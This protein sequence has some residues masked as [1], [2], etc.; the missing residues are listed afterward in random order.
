MARPVK[1]RLICSLPQ[2]ALFIPS[3]KENT[4][5]VV[6]GVDEY[7]T[8]RLIDYLGFTQEE[9]AGQ[10]NVARTTV[11]S[12]YDTARK[13][14]ADFLVNGKSLVIDGGNYDICVNSG[15]CCGKSCEEKRCANGE[16]HCQH[17]FQIK[18]KNGGILM[19]IA[20]TYEN[21]EVFQHF[22]HCENFKI[23][24]I[25]DKAVKTA[26]VVS[27][28]G[29]G[30]GALAGFLND[31]DVDILICG[32]IGG[33]AR[34]A[35]DEAGI[36]LYPGVVGNAD[37][38]VNAL[39]RDALEFNPNTMCEHHHDGDHDCGDPCGEDKHGCGGNH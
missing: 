7:E 37:E 30:H 12:V 6:L 16:L 33:G 17:A 38:S 2:T 13:K 14:V 11:Q 25:E 31:N 32:G 15:Q 36:K 4:E 8:L 39:L 21:G 1:Q 9:C 35:L 19:K 23:Y 20:V 34:V 27:A 10:M 29:S 26:Q 5:D 18:L 28:I 22:G 3:D 24:T